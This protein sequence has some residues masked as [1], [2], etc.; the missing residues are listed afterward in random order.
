MNDVCT[1]SDFTKPVIMGILNVTPDSFSDG[2]TFYNHDVAVAHAL[3]MA[4]EGADIIDIGG[5]SS[6]PGSLPVSVEEELGRV[7]TVISAIRLKSQIPI[8]I[9]TVKAPVARKALESGANMI[10]DISAG[11]FDPEMF[12]VAADA[13]VPI[14]L[15]HLRGRPRTMQ[16]GNIHYD[17]V[18]L[19]IAEYLK[20]RADTA[21]KAGIRKENILIDPGIGFGK[22]AEHNVEI[23]KRLKELKL[24]DYPII[25]GASRKSFIGKILNNQNSKERLEG[26][27]ATVAVSYRNGANVF[28]VHDV[29]PT[30]KFLAVLSQF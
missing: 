5:E 11:S 29:G 22:T 15:M 10:N 17:D 25:I 7:I 13:G 20:K 24:L 28:R 21:I 30:K 19:E 18:V 6:R 14:C 2:G 8:S 9:D 23:L 26:S 12:K 4:D 1:I 27:L 16:S 3:K